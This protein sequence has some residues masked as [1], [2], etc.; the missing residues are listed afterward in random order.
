MHLLAVAGSHNTTTD[1]IK[2]NFKKIIFS[3]RYLYVLDILNNSE[4]RKKILKSL[5]T[6]YLENHHLLSY[7]FDALHNG[8]L[9]DALEIENPY[10]C[11]LTVSSSALLV[12]K[13]FVLNLTK[14][15]AKIINKS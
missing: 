12:T 15:S 2:L 7:K 4:K 5:I 9:C 11:D 3:F 14:I 10:T 6:Y 8:G 1:K 13:L